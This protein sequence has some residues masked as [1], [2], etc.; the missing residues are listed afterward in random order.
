MGVLTSCQPFY[1]DTDIGNGDVLP[2]VFDAEHKRN[3]LS[4]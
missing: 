4:F 1:I 2:R 3:L